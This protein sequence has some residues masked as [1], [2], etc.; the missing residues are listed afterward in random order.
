MKNFRPFITIIILVST[1]LFTGEI[2]SEI[3][4]VV[5]I[6]SYHPTFMWTREL[7]EGV[8]NT[9]SESEGYRISIEY[10]D[11]KRFYNEAHLEAVKE[12]F[13]IK[14]S[15]LNVD[16]IICSDNHAF[17][18]F[19]KYGNEI[20][21]DK[22]MVF[23]GVNN[24]R[25]FAID[26]SKYKGIAEDIDI[27]GTLEI[28]M[29]LQP[30][31]EELIV[32]SDSSLTGLL[33]MDQFKRTITKFP[34]LKYSAIHAVSAT[35]L[36]HELSNYAPKNRAIYI[37]SLY[38]PREG[39]TRDMIEEA[40]FLQ[41][42]LDIPIYGNWNF[43][44]GDFIIGGYIING[45]DQGVGA[46]GIM[47][48]ILNGQLEDIP[49]LAPTPQQIII[50][51]NQLKRHNLDAS[52]L[53]ESTLFINKPIGY[54]EKNKS[55]ISI[56]GSVLAFLM[57]VILVL[58]RIIALKN[59][60]ESNLKKS[61]SRLELALEGANIGLWDVDFRFNDVYTNNG[62]AE[63]LGYKKPADLNYSLKEWQ[64]IFHPQDINQIEEAFVM[65][66]QDISPAFNGEVRLK[67]SSGDYKWFA[68]HGRLTH[69]ENNKPVRMV[70][71]LMNIHFQKEFEEQLQLAKEKAEESD[72]LKSA[73]LANMSH[74]IRT[75]MN[76]ILGFSDILLY[77]QANREEF[78]N[79]LGMIR[80]SGESLLNL[81]N[82]II[83][84]S[85][86]ESGQI[87]LKPETFDLH[88]LL[89]NVALVAQTLIKSKKKDITLVI[90]KE[91]SQ[92]ELIINADPFRVEQ[93]L[94]NLLNNAIKFT[95]SG[96]VE[97]SYEIQQPDMLTF[98]VSDSGRGIAP[99]D[100][101][102]I[103]ERFRQAPNGS[104][105]NSGGTGLGLAISKSLVH[106]MGGKIYVESDIDQG[107]T[108]TFHIPFKPETASLKTFAQKHN[109]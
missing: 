87:K 95:A 53:P 31:L 64:S 98:R 99:N 39:A 1:F 109:L 93:V 71:I 88:N 63:L 60:A 84:I 25:D 36:G 56:I 78:L 81:I 69:K 35:Q 18:F 43:L 2:K 19:L 12:Y 32:V 67:T 41:S 68:L 50:D 54:F 38:I 34:D 79:Y 55:E 51:Y 94:Y 6:N 49:F 97:L 46:A 80:K 26:S 74:E 58:T 75:P 17:E 40:A 61:E 101:A 100:H 5:L 8:V 73:F 77:D 89:D 44:F 45:R 72:R 14:Y 83:D 57:L 108:F 91:L 85:K 23:C 92:K 10:M 9:L 33:F 86:I 7:T 104:N 59:K 103:F 105:D 11:T 102:I 42:C 66:A 27:A 65:H 4:D 3:K 22:P 107:A 15:P 28:I 29:S 21:G 106:L 70:G 62:I 90:K 16:G 76:A 82:D 37:L 96:I 52:K 24:I 47:R 48:S 20:W 30:N 13:K